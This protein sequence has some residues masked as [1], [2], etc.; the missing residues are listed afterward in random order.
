MERFTVVIHNFDMA[1][2]LFKRYLN[3]NYRITQTE[4]RLPYKLVCALTFSAG[5][6]RISGIAGTNSYSGLNCTQEI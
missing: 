4:R 1:A 5:R 3:N 2:I 6:A